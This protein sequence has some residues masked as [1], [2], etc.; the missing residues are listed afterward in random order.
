MLEPGHPELSIARQCELVGLPRSSWYY[1]PREVSEQN[2]ELMRRLDEEYTKAPFYGSRRMTAWLSGLGYDVNRKRVGRLMRLMGLEAIYPRPNL[3]KP[4][5]GHRVFPYLPRNLTVERPDHVWSTDITYIRM[6]GGFVY[7]VAIMDWY[8]RYVLAWELSNTLSMDFCL[9]TLER[10]LRRGC[11][12][13]FN[14]DQ[15]SQFTSDDFTGLLLAAG[16]KVSM[17][18]RGRALDNIFV[19]RL[20]RSVKYEEVYLKDYESVPAAVTNLTAYFVFYNTERPHQSL[21]YKT[22][23]SVYF[24]ARQS[25]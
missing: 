6:R 24:G 25:A 14:T 10:S 8:S 16:V 19:E 1:K 4:C 11:P 21:G 15:G 18:G 13:I 7:L 3:S 17:D 5:P 20:W 2:L 12:E 23:A 9:A 22:P